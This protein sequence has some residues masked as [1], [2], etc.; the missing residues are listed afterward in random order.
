MTEVVGS[1]AAKK[2]VVAASRPSCPR[3]GWRSAA[4]DGDV[5]STEGDDRGR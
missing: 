3:S 2:R 4:G 1:T 5:K